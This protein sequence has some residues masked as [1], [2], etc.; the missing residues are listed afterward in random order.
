MW[1][2]AIHRSGNML[3]ALAFFL[4]VLTV[5][6]LVAVT[7]A[8]KGIQKQVLV[9]CLM[10]FFASCF[11]IWAIHLTPQWRD[12]SSDSITYQLHA[13]ALALH[14]L[15]Y[16]V[17]AAAYQLNGFLNWSSLNNPHSP[18]KHSVLG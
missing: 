13:Q 4:V 9:L 8:E 3:T 16:S 1:L 6:G 11:K 7:L 15:G 17:D 18:H 14:W 2:E 12:V 10:G 5:V